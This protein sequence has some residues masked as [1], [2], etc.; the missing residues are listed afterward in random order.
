M[1]K[2]SQL[3]HKVS[4][5][6][7]EYTI[8]HALKEGHLSFYL[9]FQWAGE[10]S[11]DGIGGKCVKDPLTIYASWDVNDCDD[12]VTF[13]TTLRALLEDTF[14]L[15]EPL[16]DGPFDSE[17]LEIFMRIREALLVELAR[18]DLWIEKG[19]KK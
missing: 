3:A 15:M 13:K 19:T 18:V 10:P 9:P 6:A 1:I 14:D 8:E 16:D 5:Y 12:R 7:R 17:S 11:N 2:K 4:K